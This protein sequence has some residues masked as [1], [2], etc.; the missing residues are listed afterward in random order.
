MKLQG[1]FRQLDIIINW[2]EQLERH[3]PSMMGWVCCKTFKIMSWSDLNYILLG[4][5]MFLRNLSEGYIIF[6]L[7]VSW[8][9]CKL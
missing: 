4:R 7:S 8:A 6:K 1:Q 2:E 3:M 5:M 9:L